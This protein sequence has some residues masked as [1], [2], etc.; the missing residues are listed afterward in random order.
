MPTWEIIQ[1]F[2]NGDDAE[3]TIGNH[4][5]KILNKDS[6]ENFQQ[7]EFGETA[8][9]SSVQNKKGAKKE[10]FL[11]NL[12][13]FTTESIGLFSL[14]A[15]KS[16]NINFRRSSRRHTR[17]P[18]LNVYKRS[19]F[20]YTVSNVHKTLEKLFGNIYKSIEKCLVLTI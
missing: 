2:D 7:K 14:P 8:I 13:S 4:L 6:I 19:Q 1:T 3:K 5:K 12:I 11:F 10:E 18:T 15:I 20:A 17:Y 9:K 16:A